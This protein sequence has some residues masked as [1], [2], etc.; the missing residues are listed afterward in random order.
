EAPDQAHAGVAERAELA[1]EAIEVPLTVAAGP[2]P[3]VDVPA[4]ESRGLA[5]GEGLAGGPRGTP[6]PRLPHGAP[7][8]PCARPAPR[9]VPGQECGGQ[10]LQLGADGRD[11][12]AQQGGGPGRVEWRRRLAHASRAGGGVVPTAGGPR[13]PPPRGARSRPRASAPRSGARPAAPR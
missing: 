13:R 11:R 8:P 6:P 4:A 9:P 12:G 10:A 7:H 2:G 5:A 1:E 3:L